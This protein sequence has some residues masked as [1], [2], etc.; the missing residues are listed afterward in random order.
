MHATAFVSVDR[1]A[2]HRPFEGIAKPL[3]R[4]MIR[5]EKVNLRSVIIE[6]KR[7]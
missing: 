4:I 1:T 6:K 7:K 5:Y 2:S 3:P